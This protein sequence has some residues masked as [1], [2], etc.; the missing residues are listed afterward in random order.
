M[1]R[2][3]GPDSIWKGIQ[4]FQDD[5]EK[6]RKVTKFKAGQGLSYLDMLVAGKVLA[7]G[8]RPGL[9]RPGHQGGSWKAD[10]RLQGQWE[11]GG[12][13]L[14]TQR[15]QGCSWGGDGLSREGH[16]A[17]APASFLTQSWEKGSRAKRGPLA[18]AAGGPVGIIA[19]SAA[20]SPCW[21][22]ECF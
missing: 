9:G 3:E 14:G 16:P 10:W 1:G 4:G 17:A 5:P 18:S 8:T 21:K 19:D 13:G 11:A 20:G 6:A 2:S 7:A 22:S 15:M 12:Q